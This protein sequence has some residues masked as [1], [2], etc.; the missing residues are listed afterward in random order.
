MPHNVT[1]WIE[2]CHDGSFNTYVDK[3]LISDEGACALE[4]ILNVTIAGWRRL[5]SS[6]VRAALRAVTG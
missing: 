3:S 6:T 2:D 5:D 4:K 1:I